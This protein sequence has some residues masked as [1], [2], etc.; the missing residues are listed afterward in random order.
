MIRGN[1]RGTDVN[2]FK[3]FL[4][5]TVVGGLMFLIPVVLII[6]VLKHAMQF[7]ARWL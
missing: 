5:T 7:A 6:V 4:K 3:N 1:E 2:A